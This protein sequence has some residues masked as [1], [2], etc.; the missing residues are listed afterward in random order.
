MTLFPH[1]NRT[2]SHNFRGLHRMQSFED[3]I[4]VQLND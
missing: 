1:Q 3:F 2:L 4:L